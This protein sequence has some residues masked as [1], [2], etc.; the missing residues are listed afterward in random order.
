M[1]GKADLPMKPCAACGR[2]FAWRKKWE[3]VWDDVRYCSDRCR[4][5][6]KRAGAGPEQAAERW[7]AAGS[8]DTSGPAMIAAALSTTQPSRRGVSAL[9]RS[10]PR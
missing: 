4:R 5:G 1:R 9:N 2:P 7:A 8:R 6:G 10:G 3:R